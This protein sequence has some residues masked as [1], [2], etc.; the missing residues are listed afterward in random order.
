M[1]PTRVLLCVRCW[2]LGRSWRGLS[3]WEAEGSLPL[4]LGSQVLGVWHTQGVSGLW[5]C[6]APARTPLL[7]AVRPGWPRGGWTP[8]C[9]CQRPD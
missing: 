1:K 2:P 9:R 7:W 5:D 3:G 8:G 4:R 6:T